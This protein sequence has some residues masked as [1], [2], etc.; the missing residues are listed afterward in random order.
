[1]SIYKKNISNNIL[2]RNNI[3]K[4]NYGSDILKSIPRSLHRKNIGWC[5][6]TIPFF[7]NDIWTLYELSWLNN[8]GLPQISIG[9]IIFNANSKNLIESKSLK[10]YMH[11]FNQNKF[12]SWSDIR[13][14][15]E[16]DLSICTES[17]VCVSLFRLN[18]IKVQSINHFSGYCIDEQD[19]EIDDYYVN[20][21]YLSNSTSNKIVTETLISHLFKSNCP[22]TNHPDW[23]SIMI[24]YTG[25]S[26]NYELLLRYLI[27]FRNQNEFH[28][29]CVERIFNDI[30][31]FCH[32][33]K[34]TVYARYTRR[35]G[36]DINPWRSNVPFSPVCLRLVR[37]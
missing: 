30:L 17:K 25:S 8:K 3:I 6:K 24:S 2:L 36:I 27:S 31:C 26:I 12:N 18:E 34:L 1:M 7:G 28:E 19:I 33:E 9:K 4:K 29:H 21:N 5:S 37:Q 10:L 13:E 35:G 15:L 20:P 32:P 11:S 22:I 14:I 16:R 23:G